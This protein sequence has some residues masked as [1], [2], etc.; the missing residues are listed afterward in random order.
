MLAGK[1]A[2][3]TGAASGIGRGS[4]LALAAAGAQVA[5]ADI[6]G[7]GAHATVAAIE[8]G[9]GKGLAV[10]LDVTDP[11]A[12]AAAVHAVVERFGG[13]DLA[14]NNAGT[15]GTLTSVAGCSLEEW[16]RVLALNLTGVFL[17]MQQE[18]PAM[19]AR[20][21]G[22]IVNTSSGAGLVGFPGLPAYVASKHGVVGL[23]KSAALEL[24]SDG[25][26]VNAICPG[27]TATPMIEAFVGADP[28]IERQ[29]RATC[30]NGRM[31]TPEEIAAAAL[32]LLS[33]AASYVSGVA[34]PI[35]AG[36]VAQ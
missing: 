17:C 3:V 10:E 7:P 35:D 27:T 34:L 14:H 24:A 2:F 23:T 21:G 12:V 6:D 15:S 4:A 36:A 20:G 31:A 22:A 28:R 25:I 11:D 26:R 30:P 8:A 32:W 13:L 1:V 16:Q 29:L 19:V 9:G 18:I 33:P 5:A